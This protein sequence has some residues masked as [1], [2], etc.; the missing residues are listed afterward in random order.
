MRTEFVRGLTKKFDRLDKSNEC[1]DHEWR[2]IYGTFERIKGGLLYIGHD[3]PEFDDFF[4][5][6]MIFLREYEI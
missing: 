2:A 4:T 1:S 6:D 5:D 3:E